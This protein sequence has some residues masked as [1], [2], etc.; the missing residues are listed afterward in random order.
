[1]ATSLSQPLIC[2]PVRNLLR[3]FSNQF[4]DFSCDDS[5]NNTVPIWEDV[6]WG[7]LHEIAIYS[8]RRSPCCRGSWGVPGL[9]IWNHVSIP[10]HW[11]V[12]SMRP[13]IPLF[14]AFLTDVLSLQ[15]LDY[16]RSWF[17]APC[18]AHLTKLQNILKL[19]IQPSTILFTPLGPMCVP[20]EPCPKNLNGIF[21]IQI[22]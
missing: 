20:I 13:D 6:Q 10:R 15:T 16:Y 5:V 19:Y 2:Q 11:Y 12:L 1:M 9:Y 3:H 4:T 14:T 21:S 8:P 17:L 22:Q 18:H 7:C